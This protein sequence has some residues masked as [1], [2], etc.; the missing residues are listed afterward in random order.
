MRRTRSRVWLFLSLRM[1]YRLNYFNCL[2]SPHTLHLTDPKFA[3]L[4]MSRLGDW[5]YAPCHPDT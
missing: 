4:A 2:P 5:P 1:L 3:S